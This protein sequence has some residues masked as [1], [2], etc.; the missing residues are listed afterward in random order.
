M[1]SRQK[2]TNQFPLWR[3]IS[4]I[5]S[6]FWT[7]K[8][9]IVVYNNK[10]S[11]CTCDFQCKAYIRENCTQSVLF[12]A[13]WFCSVYLF[14]GESELNAL[15]RERSILIKAAEDCRREHIQ[16]KGVLSNSCEA[17]SI[18]GIS[19]IQHLF[20]FLLS[21]AHISMCRLHD[22]RKTDWC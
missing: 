3:V 1:S 18:L 17:Q 15:R 16:A 7:Y 2:T 4:W 21:C 22:P 20:L 12:N 14:L 10:N 8:C 6:N 5:I 11:T 19:F 13:V 9:F